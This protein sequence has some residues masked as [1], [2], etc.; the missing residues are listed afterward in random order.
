MADFTIRIGISSGPKKVFSSVTHVLL[1]S[2]FEE[3]FDLC[4]CDLWVGS[5][6]VEKFIINIKVVCPFANIGE[7]FF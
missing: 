6:C 3:L 4:F 1:S 7:F 5:K 2:K